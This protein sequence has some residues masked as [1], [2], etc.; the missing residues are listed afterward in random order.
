M[1]HDREEQIFPKDYDRCLRNRYNDEKIWG[2]LNFG[3]TTNEQSCLYA[4][5]PVRR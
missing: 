3:E 4:R 1:Y 5:K 2:F